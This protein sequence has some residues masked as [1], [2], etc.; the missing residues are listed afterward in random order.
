MSNTGEI[1]SKI[2]NHQTTQYS[3]S[4]DILALN[5]LKP[6]M[7]DRYLPITNSSMRPYNLASI[8]NDIVIN[9]RSKILEFG[10]GTSTILITRLIKSNNLNCCITSI[11]HDVNWIKSVEKYIHDDGTLNNVEFIHAPL[12]NSGNKNGLEWYDLHRNSFLEKENFFDLVIID[13]PPAWE[14]GKNMTRYPAYPFIENKLSDNSVV[15]LDD[16]DRGGEMAILKKW[17][18]LYGIKFQFAGSSLAYYTKGNYYNP[19]IGRR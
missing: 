1:L 5:I 12:S 15:Y 8:L 6:L 17:E 16:I 4:C 9:N 7:N 18:E 2:L 3:T 13:G 11:D 14:K 10:S 19:I